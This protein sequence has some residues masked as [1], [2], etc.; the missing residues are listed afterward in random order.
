MSTVLI[1]G[2]SR[3]IGFETVK[4]A[5]KA[6]HSVA[7]SAATC[8]LTAL[9]VAPSSLATV[10]ND[11]RS[12]TRTKVLI[13]SRRSMANSFQFGMN[14]RLSLRLLARGGLIYFTGRQL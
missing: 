9:C 7:S 1:V 12:T 10:E 14:V 3:G 11:P 13:A 5:L 8:L 2:A 6:G 4:L